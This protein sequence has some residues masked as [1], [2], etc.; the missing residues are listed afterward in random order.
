MDE[1]P[2]SSPSASTP[3][4]SPLSPQFRWWHLVIIAIAFFTFPLLGVVLAI[5]YL[6]MQFKR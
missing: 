5:S 3:A 2:Y 6:A 4:T 1:N